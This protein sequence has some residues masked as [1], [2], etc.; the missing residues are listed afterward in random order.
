MPL[1]VFGM[2]STDRSAALDAFGSENRIDVERAIGELRAGRPVRVSHGSQSYVVAAAETVLARWDEANLFLTRKARLA[3]PLE[4]LVFIGAQN[5]TAATCRL[6]ALMREDLEQLLT[7]QT[8]SRL[9]TLRAAKPIETAAIDLMKF[10]QLLPAAIVDDGVGDNTRDWMVPVTLDA[11]RTYHHEV[12]VDLEIVARAPVP[13]SEDADAE[14]VVFR[15]S[16]GLKDQVAIVVGRP[17]GQTAVPVRMHSACL[18]GDLFGSLKCDCG[19]Q[20]RRA[21]RHFAEIGGGVLLYLDQEGRGIGLSNKMRAYALQAQGFDTVD[22]DMVL[23]YG[24]DERRYEIAA[25][26]VRLLGF[27]R[28]S[29]LTNNPK[30]IAALAAHGVEVADRIALVGTMNPHNE[31]YLRVKSERSG[32]LAEFPGD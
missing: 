12:T 16:D 4:R 11:I 20:L 23:G 2:A 24:P 8:V 13:L 26:M 5:N 25:K 1:P 3:L 9:P 27:K 7:A 19:E 17:D 6:D 10:A 29:L 31:R 30:K 18:T 21:V 22:A 32:H 15:G 14:F 28:V